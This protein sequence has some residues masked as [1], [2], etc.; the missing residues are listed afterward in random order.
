MKK[1]LDDQE[2][3]GK[4]A[5]SANVL[6]EVKE[7]MEKQGGKPEI[8]VAE[9]KALSNTKVCNFTR[10]FPVNNNILIFSGPGWCFEA[11]QIHLCRHK[12]SSV[13]R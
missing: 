2:R 5:V 4:A 10:L 12:C 1:S 9:L 6:T 8:F 13:Q 11:S 3:A 7:L